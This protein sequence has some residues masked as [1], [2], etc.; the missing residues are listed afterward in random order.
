VKTEREIR[1]YRDD[2]RR[3]LAMPPEQFC[4]ASAEGKVLGTGCCMTCLLI[5]QRYRQAIV[6]LDWALDENMCM[7]N[8]VEATAKLVR[9]KS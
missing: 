5:L 6:V 8:I 3:A 2:M 1:A 7:D 9:E 4:E